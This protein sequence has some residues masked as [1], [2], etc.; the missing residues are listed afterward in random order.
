[1][2]LH[3]LTAAAAALAA[4]PSTSAPAAA[5][6]ASSG[7]RASA[8]SAYSSANSGSSSGGG[9]GRRINFGSAS[10][11]S[12][13]AP[14]AD[15]SAL[16]VGG[17][18][19]GGGSGTGG[20]GSYGGF[21]SGGSEQGSG[22]SSDSGMLAGMAKAVGSALFFPLA[23][24]TGSST[25]VQVPTPPPAQSSGGGASGF[26]PAQTSF[27]MLPR[28]RGNAL[29]LLQPVPFA[30]SESSPHSHRRPLHSQ[31]A[32]LRQAIH[33]QQQASVQTQYLSSLL[34]SP[35]FSPDD[36]ADPPPFYLPPLPYPF[37][38]SV[39]AI[40][41]LARE[42]HEKSG[43]ASEYLVFASH[44]GS[45]M[46]PLTPQQER[47][48][49][50]GAA[51]SANSSAAEAHA[52]RQY[53][54]CIQLVPARYFQPDFSVANEALMFY[55]QQL[56]AAAAEA[57]QEE[58]EENKRREAQ[59]NGTALTVQPSASSSPLAS[60]SASSFYSTFS[61]PQPPRSTGSGGGL[62]SARGAG[63]GRN[64]A[65]AAQ[66]DTAFFQAAWAATHAP[67]QPGAD[68]V[69]IVP[70]MVDAVFVTPAKAAAS[71]YKMFNKMTGGP[72]SLSPTAGGAAAL[73]ASS[74]QR[75]MGALSSKRGGPGSARGA[76]SSSPLP[77]PT[78]EDLNALQLQQRLAGYL[79]LV[80]VTLMQL[81]SSKSKSFF[82]SLATIQMLN[83]E[84]DAALLATKQ[85]RQGVLV[86]QERLVEDSLVVVRNE[87]SL[88][89]ARHTLAL[90]ELVRAV[91]HTQSTVKTLLG[92]SEF[93]AAIQL[94]HATL[95]VI[96]MPQ[97]RRLRC[98]AQTEIKL[99]ENLK[100]IDMLMMAEF[101]ALAMPEEEEEG[102]GGGGETAQLLVADADTPLLQLKSSL[103]ADARMSPGDLE[104]LVPL[105]QTLYSFGTILPTLLKYSQELREHVQLQL[106]QF[107][108][109]ELAEAQKIMP[110]SATAAASAS[111]PGPS[112]SP[113]NA[114]LGLTSSTSMGNLSTVTVAM[115]VNPARAACVAAATSTAAP[116]SSPA[117]SATASSAAPAGPASNAAS[118]MASWVPNAL[119]RA[120]STVSSSTAIT[121]APEQPPTAPAE[122]DFTGAASSPPAS[123]SAAG[124]TASSSLGSLSAQA[125]GTQPEP[126]PPAAGV[127]AVN[128][129]A[130]LVSLVSSFSHGAFLRFQTRLHAR[131][132][133]LIYRA[134]GVRQGVLD[135]VAMISDTNTKENAAGNAA[136][137]A[138][139]PVQMHSISP[140][141]L[142][143]EFT[144]LFRGLICQSK[145]GGPEAGCI[146]HLC[147][148]LIEPRAAAHAA[149]GLG[150]LKQLV[151]CTMEFVR[152]A[153]SVAGSPCM[154]L[155]R[156]LLAHEKAFLA[157]FH[158]RLVGELTAAL[159]RD[160][161]ERVDVPRAFQVL[162]DSQ[163][164]R[165]TRGLRPPGS[166]GA[167]NAAGSGT[168][169][170]AE[171]DEGEED[172]ES[173]ATAAT[174]LFIENDSSTAA[175]AA[176][177]ADAVVDGMAP[178]PYA[179]YPV[180]SSVLT[181]L[182]LLSQYCQ[183]AS[184]LKGV[185]LDILS[186]VVELLTIFNS[187]SVQLILGAG[188]MHLNPAIRSITSKQLALTTQCL[189]LL[190]TQ[191]PVLRATLAAHFPPKFHAQLHRDL[192]RV[193]KDYTDHL[194]ELLAKLR[195]MAM[196]VAE[197][198]CRGSVLWIKRE[199][200]IAALAA[201]AS[202][203]SKQATGAP[204]AAVAAPTN[205]LPSLF[206]QS[207]RLLTQTDALYQVV[208][209]VLQPDQ[210]AQLMGDIARGYVRVFHAHFNT[211]SGGGIV[212]GQL[213]SG[214]LRSK[215]S[216]RV[217]ATLERFRAWISPQEFAAMKQELA[218]YIIQPSAAS[219]GAGGAVG[220]GAGA[221]AGSA[222]PGLSVSPSPVPSPTLPLSAASSAPTTPVT[223]TAD[224]IP[225][226]SAVEAKSDG[227]Q[228][229]SAATAASAALDVAPAG[230]TDN[231]T[232]AAA[233]SAPDASLLPFASSS[234]PIADG[235]SSPVASSSSELP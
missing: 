191:L 194:G 65:T 85:I 211:A 224:V 228:P 1:M 163:F 130:Q 59:A 89:A 166:D 230:A 205:T 154:E 177:S 182:H 113:A 109:N 227:H 118:F 24:I 149:L 162:V 212:A 158:T 49:R 83:G 46:H 132:L 84:I 99:R 111:A 226:S 20:G 140:E 129:V 51:S 152:E 27:P 150:P 168:W 91:S 80:E 62:G 137:T 64:G 186:R 108:A 120:G 13:S 235:D 8:S 203:P 216:K 170:D 115:P 127:A 44:H 106:V 69:G 4:A 180:T 32:A 174:Y 75:A 90:L 43:T 123:A 206:K 223:S 55:E 2:P 42:V 88:R 82:Q 72:R 176:A 68:S 23:S 101:V 167:H 161:W 187:R 190:L 119:R 179:K 93:L 41:A 58:E 103:R 208:Q 138:T 105:V 110:T 200:E 215:L 145:D 188:A 164:M 54:R 19:P 209:E 165:R 117:S 57:E 156:V 233:A 29:E 219:L 112:A 133:R 217:E 67:S 214:V 189:A 181:L 231:G 169:A 52:A 15:L 10:S 74:H 142:Q 78:A 199:E 81:V 5:A 63:S 70:G 86:L 146:E 21:G 107:C 143:R 218:I 34:N 37:N 14:R 98:L 60:S 202:A 160:L 195:S 87:R 114:A 12:A 102:S 9:A 134:V 225:A 148:R 125:S 71:L 56:A 124:L 122:G 97:L 192:E 116:S 126:S 151:E 201:S 121:A 139:A 6:A 178:S 50:E 48:Q 79:D 184:Q 47:E 26:D 31:Q 38:E 7:S 185:S 135:A 76:F 136:A 196:E 25:P 35:S 147:T 96:K 232:T 131:I 18:G 22:S 207:S 144:D 92:T 73:Y 229:V 193:R 94:V 213:S 172:E 222:T 234:Q 220:A 16:G 198:S 221:G 66:R 210:R 95:E 183:C 3:L 157:A 155:R 61:S 36:L 171:E 153:E 104:R 159:E 173:G 17:S 11:S 77:A 40:R 100:L 53:Q 175:T 33:A 128:P 28:Y 30:A 141:R 45:W 197:A 39:T 204:P